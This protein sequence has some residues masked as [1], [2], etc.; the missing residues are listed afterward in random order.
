MLI[1][2]YN[3]LLGTLLGRCLLF[4]VPEWLEKERV[5]LCLFLKMGRVQVRKILEHQCPILK[6]QTRA[7]K[8]SLHDAQ[9]AETGLLRTQLHTKHPIPSP[10]R[11]SVQGEEGLCLRV[12][13]PDRKSVV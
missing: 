9:Q 7:S 8:S 12:L 4:L 13:L 6:V 11:L 1:W 10:P 5:Q 2:I 3:R